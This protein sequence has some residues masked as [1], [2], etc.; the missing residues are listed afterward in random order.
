VK[1][2]EMPKWLSPTE[3]IQ[4]SK[5]KQKGNEIQKKKKCKNQGVTERHHVEAEWP[6]GC[7]EGGGHLVRF[8]HFYLMVAR[9][10]VQEA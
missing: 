9:I 8:L 6:V 2:K 7:N 10:G 5:F 1:I 4:N 3:L